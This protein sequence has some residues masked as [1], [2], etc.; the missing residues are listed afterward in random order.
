MCLLVMKSIGFPVQCLFLFCVRIISRNA[1]FFSLTERVDVH[2]CRLPCVR[3]STSHNAHSGALSCILV[4]CCAL[5]WRPLSP[6][7]EHGYLKEAP[8][9]RHFV[10][11][12]RDA[13]VLFYFFTL[14]C[15]MSYAMFEVSCRVTKFCIYR[16]IAFPAFY[17][18]DFLEIFGYF[19][20]SSC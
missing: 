16:S 2:W 15:F 17:L 3:F 10:H 11:I 20:I 12:R 13:A 6:R 7:K 9:F 1:E 4:V 18:H 5:H 19:S 8:S 14:S